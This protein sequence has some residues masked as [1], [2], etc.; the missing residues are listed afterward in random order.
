M[1]CNS[2]E[3]EPGTCKDRDILRFNPHQL[4]EGMALVVMRWVLQW[5]ITIFVVNFGNLLSVVKQL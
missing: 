3:G 2:D 1:L 5:V 4:I